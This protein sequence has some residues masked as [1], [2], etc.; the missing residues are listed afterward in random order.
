MYYSTNI[1]GKLT[2]DESKK[3]LTTDIL[4]VVKTNQMRISLTVG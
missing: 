2:T 4:G 3:V 1:K